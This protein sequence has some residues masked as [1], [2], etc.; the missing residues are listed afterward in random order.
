MEKKRSQMNQDADAN[1]SYEQQ[2]EIL[3]EETKRMN[4]EIK[5]LQEQLE[6]AKNKKIYAEDLADKIA[7]EFTQ[8]QEFSSEIIKSQ[9]FLRYEEECEDKAKQRMKEMIFLESQREETKRMIAEV[10][11]LNKTFENTKEYKEQTE[12]MVE[13]I[14]IQIDEQNELIEKNIKSQEE[15]LKNRDSEDKSVQKARNI[16]FL[17]LKKQGEIEQEARNFNEILANHER[18]RKKRSQ[19]FEQKM[20]IERQRQQIERINHHRK[21][22]I[23]SRMEKLV[24]KQ[25]QKQE[26]LE[27]KWTE[28]LDKNEREWAERVSHVK[29][30]KL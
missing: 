20:E 11:R 5:Q 15:I 27:K 23:D 14:E 3:K 25:K 18:I 9:E 22:I 21:E 30:E 19:E 2:L 4:A 1:I 10:A 12:Q 16:T 26:A 29:S 8:Q 17:Q 13:N 28:R 24:I 7:M 6:E